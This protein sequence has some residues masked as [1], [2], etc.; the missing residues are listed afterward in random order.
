[1][2]KMAT[3]QEMFD[4]WQKMFAPGAAQMQSMMFPDLK[5]VEKKIGDLEAVEAWLKAN[6]GLLQMSIKAL[7]YQRAMLKG[8]EAA[9]TSYSGP[10]QAPPSAQYPSMWTWDMLT[11]TPDGPAPKKRKKR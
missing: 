10:Q 11:R 4:L 2:S 5:D 3:P 8:G 1:M 9:K 7:E 6:L